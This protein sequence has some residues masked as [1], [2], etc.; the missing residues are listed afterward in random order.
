VWSP[1]PEAAVSI[2]LVGVVGAGTMGAGIAEVFARAG[3]PVTAVDVDGQTLAAARER[4]R[5]SLDRADASGKLTH[6]V[7]EIVSRIH[8]TGSLGALAECDLVVEA[9]V[10]SEPAKLEVFHALAARCRRDTILASNSSSIP[11]VRLAHGTARPGRVIGLHFF[12]PAPV[13]PLVEVVASLASDPAVVERVVA[14]CEGPLGKHVLRSRDRAGFTVSS[15]LIPFLLSAMRMVEAGVASASEIDEGMRFACA[16]SIGPLALSD[17]MGLDTVKSVADVLYDEYGDAQFAAPE[18]LEQ[19]VDT[20]R[21]GRKSG[22]G[23][24][25]YAEAS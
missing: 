14:L 20:G 25:Q 12:N 2:Q 19:M 6:P 13:Q 3:F 15:L 5:A 10:E 17:L 1:R 8:F 24:F 7:A 21:L 4:I 9:I 23:F 16:H 11:I 18:L 22:E